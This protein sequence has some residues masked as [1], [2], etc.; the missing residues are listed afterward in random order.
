MEVGDLIRKL[1]IGCA[2]TDPVLIPTP[3]HDTLENADLDHLF[4]GEHNISKT[5]ERWF[6]VT[7]DPEIPNDP[8]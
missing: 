3:H 4:I 6:I 8:E 2:P 1:I 5:W 7:I